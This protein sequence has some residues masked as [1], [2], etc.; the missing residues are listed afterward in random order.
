MASAAN[1]KV[2]KIIQ[3]GV[4]L[5]A[6]E[7]QRATVTT[8]DVVIDPFNARNYLCAIVTATSDVSVK[9]T[10]YSVTKANAA[11]IPFE[12]SG[13][14]VFK[15]LHQ[16]PVAGLFADDQTNIELTFQEENGITTQIFVIVEQPDGN[17]FT[18]RKI[19][20]DIE[21]NDSAIASST[22]QKGWLESGLYADMYDANGDLRQTG[23]DYSFDDD[24]CKRRENYM[25]TSGPAV[26]F[27]S[28]FYSHLQ[29][30]SIMG[31]NYGNLI[32]PEGY[33]FHH[34]ITWDDVGHIYTLLSK[35]E[36]P[37]DSVKR[38][39]TVVK[40]VE[41]TSEVVSMFDFSDLC[42]GALG[43]LNCAANDLHFNAINYIPEIGQVIVNSRSLNSYFGLDPTNLR[44]VWSVEDTRYPTVLPSSNVLT[45]KNPDNYTYPNGEHSV[46]PCHN[47]K[48]VQYWGKGK[49]VLALFDNASCL[50][51]NRIPLLIPIEQAP[52][53]EAGYLWPS[54]VQIVAIDLNEF[55][56]EQLDYFQFND[57]R[58]YIVSSVFD[59][60]DREH[61]EVF[62]G[63][64]GD[65]YVIDSNGN[66]GVT[67]RGLKFPE[68]YGSYRARIMR[69]EEI[70]TMINNTPLP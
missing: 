19:H 44:P 70:R 55:T 26:G 62:F 68:E 60:Y 25:Y 3:D 65:F 34:D 33:L 32:P 48:Y 49:F 58:S 46:I 24:Y 15:T 37:T 52:N 7:F 8:Q 9:W 13:P 47:K 59:S 23:L 43:N 29:K 2:V 50:D 53:E 69:F 16:I 21:V 40:M 54:G 45:I 41:E 1:F 51:E 42:T 39:A 66:I 67:V 4:E 28:H 57:D 20:I 18:G 22:I 64:P 17:L 11:S 27:D 12:N 38:E 5:L 31:Y 35:P 63:I 36:D 61:I 10:H 6:S 56:I 30:T 14:D